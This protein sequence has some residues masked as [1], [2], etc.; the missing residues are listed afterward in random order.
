[1]TSSRSYYEILGVAPTADLQ[2]LKKAF[3]KLSKALHP[4][5][6]LLPIDEA[7]NKFRKVCEAYQVLSDP[8]SRKIY[9]QSL[10]QERV[11]TNLDYVQ[12]EVT[13]NPSKS[14]LSKGDNR[15]PFSGG[16]LF[17]LLL[18]CIALSISLLLGIGIALFDGRELQVTPS[19]LNPNQSFMSDVSHLNINVNFASR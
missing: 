1:M 19:W 7:A 2:T 11:I 3:H 13:D 9:D 15:R 18:L 6:T 5:T 14:L 10:E 12:G 8:L 17:S 4:D 16:E